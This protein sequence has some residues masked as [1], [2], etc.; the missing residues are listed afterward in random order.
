[1]KA[2]KSLQSVNLK[3][4]SYGRNQGKIWLRCERGKIELKVVKLYI[5]LNKNSCDHFR[6]KSALKIPKN[7]SGLFVV[8]IREKYGV[9]MIKVVLGFIGID[10]R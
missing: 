4:G 5:F 10:I 9:H 2:S 3:P 8:S 7:V 1:M 6:R